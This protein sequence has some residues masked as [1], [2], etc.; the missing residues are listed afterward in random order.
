MRRLRASSFSLRVSPQARASYLVLSRISRTFSITASRPSPGEYRRSDFSGQGYTSV[1]EPG[2]PPNGPLGG[3]SLV[4]PPRVVPSKLKEHLDKYVVGQERAK[5]KLCTAIYNHYQRIQELQRLEDERAELDAQEQRQKMGHRHPIEDEYPGQ[6]QTVEYHP[7]VTPFPEPTPSPIEAPLPEDR[8]QLGIQKSNV[9]LLGPSGVGKTYMVKT[10]A[11]VLNVPFS[12]SACTSFTSAGYIGEDVE[13]CVQRLLAAA[14]YDVAEAERGIIFLDEIDKIATAKVNHGKDVGGEGV[15]QALLSIIEGTTL[16]IQGK[17]ERGPSGRWLEGPKSPPP[18]GAGK[19]TYTVRTDNILFICAG[20]FVNLGK[21]IQ[22]RI[23]KG[24]M[25]FGAAVRSS[26][27]ESGVHETLVKGDDALFKKHLPFY[28]APDTS[29]AGRVS[30]SLQT[31]NLLDLVEPADLQKYGMIPEFLGRIP[32][33]CALSALDEDALVRVLTEP[34]NS[35]IRQYEQLFRNS[36]VELRFTT[37]SLR[38]IAKRALNMGTGARGLRVVLER[39]LEESMYAAPG[40]CIKHILITREV[41]QLKT[42]PLHF[43]R[44]QSRS[45]YNTWNHEEALWE[46]EI[47]QLTEPDHPSSF[48]EYRK[49]GL[50][51]GAGGCM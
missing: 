30:K 15:Q 1:Y 8:G 46:D 26:K 33:L 9:L 6:E 27:P 17:A 45:F 42:A 23:A 48:Q 40:S 41:A 13:A 39:M 4:G 18:P 25:G 49:Q 38:E 11:Q 22:D 12:V 44:G 34:Q 2:L 32:T 20:A 36:G 51:A 43:E 21:I 5:K 3:A 35:L 29:P 19:E 14:K 7:P 10:L 31:F 24:S 47:R 16:Q 28:V 37:A 50:M